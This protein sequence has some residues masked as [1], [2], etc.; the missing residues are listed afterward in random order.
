MA[1][2]LQV[3]RPHA[4]AHACDGVIVYTH[5]PVFARGD[6][7]VPFWRE[8]DR[9][10]GIC[11]SSNT[12]VQLPIPS[13]IRNVI[14]VLDPSALPAYPQNAVMSGMTLGIRIKAVSL[15]VTEVKLDVTT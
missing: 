13:I 14:L 7:L 15:I 6:K 11:V 10:N 9:K 4:P 8:L 3:F 1:K 5:R 2:H 12:L